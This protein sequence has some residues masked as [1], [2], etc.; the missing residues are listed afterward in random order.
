MTFLL[1][2]K[3]KDI[4]QKSSEGLSKSYMKEFSLADATVTSGESAMS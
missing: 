4:D 2:R 3:E 1:E